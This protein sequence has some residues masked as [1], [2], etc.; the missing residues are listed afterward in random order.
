M[1]WTAKMP[2]RYEWTSNYG[3]SLGCGDILIIGTD[4]LRICSLRRL[5][6]SVHWFPLSGHTVAHSDPCNL[7]SI[8]LCKCQIGYLVFFPAK[9]SPVWGRLPADVLKILENS[10]LLVAKPYKDFA[11][12]LPLRVHWRMRPFHECAEHTHAHTRTKRLYTV[13]FCDSYSHREKISN[14]RTLY[15]LR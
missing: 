2:I 4:L 7:N 5:L 9:V 11:L 10:F 1:V 15:G 14:F 8:G 6:F 13:L 3:C 12:R